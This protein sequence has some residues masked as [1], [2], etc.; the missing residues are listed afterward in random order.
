MGTPSVGYYTATKM[1]TCCCNHDTHEAPQHKLRKR[2]QIQKTTFQ[3]DFIYI[4]LR[5]SLKKAGISWKG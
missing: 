4:N 2:S 3:H 1:E 5:I